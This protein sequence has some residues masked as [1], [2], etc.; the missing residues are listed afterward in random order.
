LLD[1]SRQPHESGPEHQCNFAGQAARNFL[2]ATGFVPGS[3]ERHSDRQNA[4]ADDSHPSTKQAHARRYG[5]RRHRVTRKITNALLIAAL[6]GGVGWLITRQGNGGAFSPPAPGSTARVSNEPR[7][8]DDL[9]ASSTNGYKQIAG[10]FT[11]RDASDVLLRDTKRNRDVHVRVLF[12]VASGRFPVILFSADDSDCCAAQLRSWGTHGYIL[13]QLAGDDF[14][15]SEGTTIETVQLRRGKRQVLSA[16]PVW[17]NYPLDLSF[18][19]DSMSELQN[20]IPQLRHKPDLDHIGVAGWG[21]GAF[22]A[23]VIAGAVIDLPRHPRANLADPRVRA[24]L[25]FSPQ[26]PGHFGLRE[27]SFEQLVLPYLGIDGA[28]FDG[29]RRGPVGW[30]RAPFERSQAGDKYEL[31]LERSDFGVNRLPNTPV[32]QTRT[33]KDNGEPGSTRGYAD[34][35][36]LAF[37]DAYLK[38]DLI[39]RRY[40]QSD[41]LEK[42]SKGSVKLERH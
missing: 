22:A 26:G 18:V 41:T 16:S 42:A 28:A 31:S 40:L 35:A 8:T 12:P 10:P 36:A 9:P 29:G 4:P 2:L 25:C 3:A 15:H 11:V 32:S 20:R 5:M 14:G 23:E 33:E 24:V 34:S 7:K 13:I 1:S 6:G 27:E 37:W 17:E 19:I 38:H 21:I 39:A 30:Q